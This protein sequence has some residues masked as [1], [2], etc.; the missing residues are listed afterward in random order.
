MRNFIYTIILVIL[1][2]C[3]CT[4]TKYIEVPVETVK[5]EYITQF[6]KDSIFIHDSIDRFKSNDTIYL[7]KYKYIYKQSNRTD[8]VIKTDTV[9]K[10][11][12]VEKTEIK[13]VNKIKWWQNIL[14]YSGVAFLVTAIAFI[15]SK[16]K[17]FIK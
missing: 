9:P 8:T 16:V 2:G 1:L 10:L 14:M 12:T 11:I 13:E 4:S 7:T 5:T 3:S 15:Y 17:T 6:N